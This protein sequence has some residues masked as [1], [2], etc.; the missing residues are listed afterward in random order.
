MAVGGDVDAD[1]GA[2]G[3]ADGGAGEAVAEAGGV[4]TSSVISATNPDTFSEIVL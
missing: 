1:E 2:E 4:A 3:G